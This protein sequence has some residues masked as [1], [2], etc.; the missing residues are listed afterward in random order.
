MKT[1]KK[2]RKPLQ[3]P[4]FSE[5]ESKQLGFWLDKIDVMVLAGYAL[6]ANE[7]WIALAAGTLTIPQG[8]ILFAETIVL[9]ATWAAI[10]RL[11]AKLS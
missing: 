3:K 9:L 6:Y 8:A 11:K 4:L 5:Q 2:R 1:A 10:G 7:N